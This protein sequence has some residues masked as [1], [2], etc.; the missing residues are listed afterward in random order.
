[1]TQKD[2]AM[3]IDILKSL[4]NLNKKLT[5]RNQS[6]YLKDSAQGTCYWYMIYKMSVP[7][8]LFVCFY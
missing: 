5:I 6:T 1:M 2:T 3:I 7:I 4:K 8:R